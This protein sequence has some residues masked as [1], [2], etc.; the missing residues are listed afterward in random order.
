[1]VN[2]SEIF[3]FSRQVWWSAGKREDFGRRRGKTKMSR[4]GGIV[5]VKTDL[6][7]LFIPRVLTT[8][9]LL[10]LFIVIVL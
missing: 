5:D 7:S 9:Y 1:M 8:Y 2:E 4:R 3:V 6:T 10:Y